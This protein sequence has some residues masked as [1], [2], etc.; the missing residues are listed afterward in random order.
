MTPTFH[1][2]A[3]EF[4]RALKD[5]AAE[6]SRTFPEVVN[7]QGLAL[8]TRA[9]KL[10]RKANANKIAVTLGQVASQ[11]FGKKGQKL[12]R[13][14]PKRV[15][16]EDRRSLGYRIAVK[17]LLESGKSF[18]DKDVVDYM[19]KLVGARIR[20]AAFIAS[21]WIYAIRT[22][23]K[24]VGYKNA[25]VVK[26]SASETARMK[27]WA[28]GYAKPATRVWS[29]IVE[30][31]IANTALIHRDGGTSPK[32]VAEAGLALAFV[33]SVKDMRRHL[34]EKMGSIFAKFYKGI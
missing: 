12:S 30:C 2:A 24:L 31:E 15:F 34:Q 20:S 32:Q 3:G 17:R 26:Y 19:R 10:T 22:L 6:S 28:K 27:G 18:T 13:R 1:V 5:I 7:G 11:A 29:G 8:A 9:L 4:N 33:D 14:R 25:G 21:G 16:A 23:S